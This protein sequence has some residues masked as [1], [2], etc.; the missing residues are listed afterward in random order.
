MVLARALLA[1]IALP[2][3]F[4]GVAPWILA[5]VDPWRSPSVRLGVVVWGLGLVIVLWCVRDFYVSGHGTLAPWDPPRHLV[6]VGL[7][8]LTRNPMYLGVLLV[9]AGSALLAGSPL[10]ALYSAVL[11]LAFHWRVVRHEEPWLSHRFP[12]E[13]DRYRRDVPRWLPRRRPWRG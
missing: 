11:L 6:V 8:R 13:W 10:V 2:G 1:F 4:A 12:A 7:Y 3:V 5:A 9:V